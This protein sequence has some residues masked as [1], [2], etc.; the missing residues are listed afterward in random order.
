MALFEWE[1]DPLKHE[2]WDPF[3]KYVEDHFAPV[4]VPDLELLSNL[5]L[6]PNG[7]SP[8]RDPAL[9]FVD[10]S[11]K[12]YESASARSDS[13]DSEETLGINRRKARPALPSKSP[14][15]SD[16]S[17]PAIENEFAQDKN[18]RLEAYPYYQRLVA[19]LVDEGQGY[20][21][22]LPIAKQKPALRE[23]IPWTGS[24]DDAAMANYHRGLEERVMLE[25]TELGLLE[26]PKND[27]VS[28]E[29]RMQQAKLRDISLKT[30]V[31]RNDLFQKVVSH[32]LKLQSKTRE[33][34]RG[35]DEMDILYLERMIRK[36]K[37]NKRV[38][39]KY[40]RMLSLLY[41]HYK[42]KKENE[43]LGVAKVTAESSATKKPP[44][45]QKKIKKKT[46]GKM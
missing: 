9:L 14:S 7:S 19:A 18:L 39:T 35:N 13:E 33:L 1:Q 4:Q 38:K 22:I 44:V 17:S 25:L 32:G 37:K 24:V 2:E 43:S 15:L 42:Q 5:D 21:S 23:E 28:V 29:L 40:Q 3:W 30:R 11:K 6:R 34:K 31:F 45:A 8:Y 26:D 41:P 12:P 10:S 16:K 46:G 36:S 20:G 27:E